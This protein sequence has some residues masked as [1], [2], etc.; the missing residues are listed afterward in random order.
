M[1][2]ERGGRRSDLVHDEK[3]E[4]NIKREGDGF[5]DEVDH[6]DRGVVKI[7]RVKAWDESRDDSDD[8][9]IISML[10]EEERARRQRERER[11]DRTRESE[12]KINKEK[13]LSPCLT[14]TW[15]AQEYSQNVN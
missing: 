12:K 2:W 6:Q 9:E 3:I 7:H 11:E 15:P 8:D 10:E 13:F 14:W 1:A 4:A 5:D